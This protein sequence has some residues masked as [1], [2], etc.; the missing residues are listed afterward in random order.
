MVV[1]VAAGLIRAACTGSVIGVLTTTWDV[2]A[3]GSSATRP[4]ETRVRTTWSVAT[5]VIAAGRR[6]A[7]QR[8]TLVQTHCERAGGSGRIGVDEVAVT[9][10][11]GPGRCL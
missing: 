3:S 7:Q 11:H 8:R 1:V 6:S 10:T 4:L 5:A 2:S 9:A